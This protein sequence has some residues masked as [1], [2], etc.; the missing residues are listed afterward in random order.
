MDEIPSYLVLAIIVVFFAWRSARRK[1]QR[2][3][4]EQAAQQARNSYTLDEIDEATVRGFTVLDADGAPLDL[5][6]LRW[7]DHGLQV[8]EV[9]AF[10][11]GE[12]G[13]SPDFA[14]GASVEL[15]SAD[16]AASIFDVWNSQMTLRAGRVRVPEAAA[17]AAAECI[18]LQE[19]RVENQRVGLRLLL[20]G[21]DMLLK[22]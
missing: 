16:D 14:P 7:E 20:M 10:P 21:E 18:V 8:V 12:L 3:A 6:S 5:Q 17:A 1:N 9:D 2:L 22:D 15:V 11:A 4:M 19:L 13:D